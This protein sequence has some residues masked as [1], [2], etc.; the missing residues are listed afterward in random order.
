MYGKYGAGELEA[1]RGVGNEFRGVAF[2]LTVSSWTSEQ[3]ERRSKTHYPRE[4]FCE[5]AWLPA[6]RSKICL[7]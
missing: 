6:S 5:D 1:D 4:T 3:G 7:G 2:A